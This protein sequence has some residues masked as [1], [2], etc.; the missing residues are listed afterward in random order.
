MFLFISF[1]FVGNRS[2]LNYL[3]LC[4]MFFYLVGVVVAV[5]VVVVVVVVVE[6]GWNV[7]KYYNFQGQ[8]VS[9]VISSLSPLAVVYVS[10]VLQQYV[11]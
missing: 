9:E 11:P 7:M 4:L 1:L 6:F 5:V 2:K 3:L 10:T 8:V